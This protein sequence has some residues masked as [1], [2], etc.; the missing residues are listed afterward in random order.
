MI[1]VNKVLR[2]LF[3]YNGIFVLAGSLLG[4]LYA[5]YVERLDTGV[6]PV[7]I[8]WAVFLFS[9]T[10]FTF[11]LSKMG[12]SLKHKRFLLA[13]G[14]LVRALCWFLMI[15]ITTIE[16]LVFIQFILGIG[17]ALGTPAFDAIFAEHLDKNKHIMDYSDW[18]VISNAVLVVGT[19]VGGFVVSKF[20]FSYVLIGMS[21]LAVISFLGV[22]INPCVDHRNHTS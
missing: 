14:Y 19:L 12:D 1:S 5:L 4:P 16:Q 9:T 15:F 10:L 17:E 11:I 7:S 13:G 21:V 3:L 6:L 20:G 18:K 22:I 2:V 8:S